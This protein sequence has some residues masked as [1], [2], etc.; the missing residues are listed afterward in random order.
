MAVLI[1]KRNFF[2]EMEFQAL[3]IKRICLLEHNYGI[4]VFSWK[5][6]SFFLVKVLIIKELT[7]ISY[8]AHVHMMH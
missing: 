3:V 1:G 7:I 8:I 5:I 2:V 4:A 6:R